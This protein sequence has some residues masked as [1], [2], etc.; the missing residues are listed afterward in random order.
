MRVERIILVILV[1]CALGKVCAQ[2]NIYKGNIQIEKNVLREVNNVVEIDL[3]VNLDS[4]EIYSR[5][6]LTLIPVLKTD[7]NQLILPEIW[8]NG[9]NRQK[10]YERR[11]LLNSGLDVYKD[12]YVILDSKKEHKVVEYK[13]TVPFESW[14]RNAHL[15][16]QQDKCGCA[17]GRALMGE[18]DLG[19]ILFRPTERYAVQPMVTFVTP[20]AEAVKDRNEI[21]EA[22]L[23]FVVGQYRILPDFRRNPQELAKVNKMISDALADKNIVI[24]GITFTGKASP[25]APYDY[26]MKLSQNRAKALLD[27]ADTGYKLKK[28]W[29]QAKSLGEDWVAF[30]KMVE[31]SGMDSRE[32]VLRI[33]DSD[34]EPDV[35]EQRLKALHGGTTYAWL[36]KEVFPQLRRVECRVDYTVRA[37]SVEE[38][39]DVLMTRPQ[40]LSLKEMFLIANTYDK[41]STD[42]NNVFEIAVRMFPEDKVANF[43]AAATALSKG[44]TDR[45]AAYL[46][47]CDPANPETFNNFGVLFLMQGD[48][49]RAGEFLSKARDNGVMEAEHN[50]LELRAKQA[51]NDLFDSFEK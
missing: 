23:D 51:D 14:M 10:V 37:F 6:T 32:E 5:K 41:G 19:G 9:T 49:E 22:F 47:V 48:L 36:N 50:L 3:L 30:R 17:D 11:K 24:N 38:G 15:F 46:E 13:T 42:F 29:L 16:I 1:S 43:N 21:G 7:S 34:E 27:Y 12:A 4:V 40:Q 18:D 26:N 20:E 33:I 25:E 28:E 2:K 45:A 39:K 8:V 35:K 31:A 44:E